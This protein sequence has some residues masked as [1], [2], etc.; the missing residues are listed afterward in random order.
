MNIFFVDRNPINAAVALCDKHVL[1]MTLESTQ[2]LCS[3]HHHYPNS[4]GTYLDVLYRQ[5]HVS[6]PCAIWARTN[7]ANYDWLLQHC[8][9]LCSEYTFRYDKEHACESL[10]RLLEIYPPSLSDGVFS[11]PPQCMPEPFRHT[12][13]VE[14]YRKYYV[15]DKGVK[16]KCIWTKRDKPSWFF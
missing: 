3:T 2:L 1:K 8:R 6:H 5:T 13:T 9:A 14:A 11:D 4:N 12:D 16:I 7:K 10:I 15:F